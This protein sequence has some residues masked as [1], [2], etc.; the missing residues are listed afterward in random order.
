MQC[1]QVK[2]ILM[3]ESNVQPVKAPVTVCGDIHGQFFDLLE[4]FRHGGQIPENN[5]IFMVRLPAACLLQNLVPFLFTVWPCSFSQSGR[6][7]GSRIPQCRN[8]AAA[9][10]T[11][12]K[13][14]CTL[15]L[16]WWSLSSH[17]DLVHL[18]NRYPQCITLL[19]GNHES[20][21]ITQVYGFYDEC[22]KKY[23]NSNPWKYCTDV[24]D[25]LSLSAVSF[26]PLCW[27]QCIN[28][29]QRA[30][31]LCWL[32]DYR[33]ASVVRARRPVARSQHHRS[34]PHD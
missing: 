32:S 34:N 22:V 28:V 30:A 14:Q 33:R 11:Q 13:V 3:E 20:R 15:V 2:E 7:G 26:A 12:S 31:L 16:H 21:Q 10:C 6:F 25:Y 27:S 8:F 24:F 17:S 19:R 4:L 18:R 9:I 23:G 5:Y 1:K 29:F